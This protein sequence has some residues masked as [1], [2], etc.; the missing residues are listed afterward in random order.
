M[1]KKINLLI[2]IVSLLFATGCGLFEKKQNG[3]KVANK[4]EKQIVMP[5]QNIILDEEE[6]LPE[7]VDPKVVRAKIVSISRDAFLNPDVSHINISL[8][9]GKSAV[10]T[11]ISLHK[12]TAPNISYTWKGSLPDGGSVMF[13]I[14]DDSGAISGKV[15]MGGVAPEIYTLKNFDNN[16][17]IFSQLK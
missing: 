3:E 4:A 8:F 13:T 2:V 16:K 12:Y 10:A 1:Y 11:K 5:P 17:Y 14:S 9:D 6:V 15:T 7:D